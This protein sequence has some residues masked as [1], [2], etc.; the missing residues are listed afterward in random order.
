MVAVALPGNV[1]PAVALVL[2][3]WPLSKKP[4]PLVHEVALER[5]KCFRA[6]ILS[7]SAEDD[8]RMVPTEHMWRY[9]SSQVI[10]V[11]DVETCD[12]EK[13]NIVLSEKSLQ[14][15]SELNTDIQIMQGAAEADDAEK[16]KKGVIKSSV[17][18]T[19][20]RRLQRSA[21]A[22]LKKTKEC[23]VEAAKAAKKPKELWAF[24]IL[25][26]L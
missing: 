15:V 2:T 8:R 6:V 23:E 16:V 13:G 17:L 9:L 21:K 19:A 22:T 10:A 7:Q 4:R 18:K 12:M 3:V 24:L 25:N 26:I 14:A 20:R 11:L 5:V 1:P